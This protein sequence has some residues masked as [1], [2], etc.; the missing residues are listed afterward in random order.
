MTNII[1][2]RFA[3]A[4][5]DGIETVGELLIKICAKKGLHVFAYRSYQS[6]IRGG[7]VWFQI[8]ISEKPLTHFGDY[9]DILVTLNKD[10]ILYDT[11]FLKEK[12]FIIHDK[13]IVKFTKEDVRKEFQDIP[14]PL[15]EIAKMYSKLPVVQNTVALGALAALLGFNFEEVK[16]IIIDTFKGKGKDIIEMNIAAARGGYEYVNNIYGK[17][18]NFSNNSERKPFISGAFSIA[19]GAFVA[20]CK[21]YAAYPMTPASPILHWLASHSKKCGIIVIQPEDEIAVI[22]MAIGAAHAGVRAMVATSGGGFALMS[23]AVG[24]AG[25]TETPVVII[26]SQRGGPSTGLPT[27]TEQGD[28]RQ[29]LGAGQSDYPKAVIAPRDIEEAYY[30]II[31]AFNLAEKYQ[32]PVIILTDLYLNESIKTLEKP[33]DYENVKIDR[34]WL[35][36]ENEIK[37]YKRYLITENGVSPRALPGQKGYN[38]VAASDEHDEKGNLV[39][40][41]LAGLPSMLEIRKKIMEKRMR[42]ENYILKE[43]ETPKIYGDED[44]DVTL[45]SWGSTRGAVREAMEIL[46]KEKVKVNSL[47]IKYLHPFQGEEIKKIL[48]KSKTILL[49]ENNYSAQVG[50]LIAQNTGI[51]I[52]HKLLRYDGEPIT[53]LQIVNKVKEI[54]KEKTEEIIIKR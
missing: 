19:F 45:V 26:N 24:L 18:F 16:E 42:K 41:V 25:M 50:G 44:A 49:I 2:I 32:I 28:V 15:I 48:Q 3:G 11:L 43:F 4:A 1:A 54:L 52:K 29:V 21:F 46:R 10:G 17:K 5:G 39:S 47:E 34:G 6:V 38:Y 30:T 22:N 31:E 14:V 33:L 9:Y 8:R 20:G 53:P 36:N 51:I 35:I 27:K 7:H 23:E 37:D 12:G 13:N 40:D